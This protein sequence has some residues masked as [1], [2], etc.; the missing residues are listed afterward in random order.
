MDEQ[1]CIISSY[2]SIMTTSSTMFFNILHGQFLFQFHPS[3]SYVAFLSPLP[4]SLPSCNH[5]HSCLK[6]SY[7]IIHWPRIP[8]LATGF[9]ATTETRLDLIPTVPP[10]TTLM[11]TSSCRIRHH[12]PTQ[13][14]QSLLHLSL[15]VQY[16][17]CFFSRC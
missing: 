10:C 13:L 16:S 5:V 17:A 4:S 9:L 6:I 3:S 1:Q 12:Q 15:S 2:H 7:L 11:I 14:E 8:R